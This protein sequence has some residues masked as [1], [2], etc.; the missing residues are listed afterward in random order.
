MSQSLSRLFVH[1]IFSTKGRYPF[2]EDSAQRAELHAYLGEVAKR[3]GFQ[4]VRVGGVADHVHLLLI[5]PRTATIADCVKEVKRVST[6]WMKEKGNSKFAWQA[7]YGVFSVS[8]S[9]VNEVEAYIR[10]QDVHHRVLSF[11]DEYRVFLQ[12]HAVAYDER[13]VWD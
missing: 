1:V 3:I 5:Q 10:D 13:Y 11:Q 6:K 8:Q 12:K 4:P 2:L 7:G 9:N